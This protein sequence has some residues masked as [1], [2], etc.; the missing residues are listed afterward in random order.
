[1]TFPATVVPLEEH[2]VTEVAGARLRIPGDVPYQV[3]RSKLGGFQEKPTDE[4]TDPVIP[5]E[6]TNIGVKFGTLTKEQFSHLHAAYGGKSQV[7][8]DPARE[9]TLLDF[10]PP[11]IQAL[12]GVQ[13]LAEPV[14]IPGLM[15]PLASTEG[16]V[17]EDFF[18]N[19]NC[20]GTSYELL[21]A[22]HPDTDPKGPVTLF[23][24]DIDAVDQLAS[25]ARWVE[26][27]KTLSGEQLAAD[28]V[29]ERNA[30]LR[31]GDAVLLYGPEG[32][33]GSR[34]L[35]HSATYVDQDLFFEK[36]N[37]DDEQ[38]AH[39]YRFATLDDMM[40]TWKAITGH[41][42]DE[43]EM[44]V[45]RGRTDG[46]PPPAREVFTVD[47]APFGSPRLQDAL[48]EQVPGDAAA[49]GKLLVGMGGRSDGADEHDAGI[50]TGSA[51]T[52]PVFDPKTGR[53]ALVAEG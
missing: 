29:E 43:L 25:D 13:L 34:E 4:F 10:M 31:P 5:E 7:P 15:Q 44:K 24:G 32:E 33:D 26:P 49:L 40:S 22:F 46:A 11:M 50:F 21:R 30:G 45:V 1:V 12:S 42:R 48:R 36:T 2:E 14:R 27:V 41:E 18:A 23:Q 47:G 17:V 52:R 28:A 53:A 8:F 38:R 20:H 9:Y 35:L 37:P 19:P 6:R 16:Q 3:T 51:I 39:P